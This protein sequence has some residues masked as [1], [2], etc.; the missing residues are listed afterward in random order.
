MKIG[1]FWYW[2]NAVIG[3]AHDVSTVDSLGLADS[4][5]THVDYWQEIQAKNKA[6]IYF[7]YEEVPRGR[8]VFNSRHNKL[9]IYMDKTLFSTD[10]KEKI[11][12]FF[13][14]KRADA[15]FKKDPHYTLMT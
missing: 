12:N 11:L 13:D 3:V 8:A 9:I 2:N 14:V 4:H 6:L 15:V 7:E 5:H 1:I 10:K